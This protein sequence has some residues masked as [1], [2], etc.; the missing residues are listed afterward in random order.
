M[1]KH[2]TV[3][4]FFFK[5]EIDIINEYLRRDAILV[6]ND[7]LADNDYSNIHTFHGH[8]HFKNNI[9]IVDCR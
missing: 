1:N 4:L 6:D 5:L 2:A 8:V 9:L 7:Y 3:T